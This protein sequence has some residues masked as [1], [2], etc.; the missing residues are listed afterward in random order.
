MNHLSREKSA[1]LQQH[2][3]NPVH[4]RAWSK[5]AFEVAARQKKP[6][7][8]SI[9]YSTC[10]WCHV[11]EH[12]SFESPE[13]AKILNDSFVA[14][15][16]DREEHPDIDQ[17]YMDALH[18]MVARGGWPLNVF[19]TPDRVPFFGGTYFPKAQFL[20]L[21]TNIEKVWR[22]ASG[23]IEEQGQKV[24]E[25]MKQGR[26]M[27]A[28]GVRPSSNETG[29]SALRSRW[30]SSI[31]ELANLQLRNF[32]SVWGGFGGAPKFPRSHA[33]SALLRAARVLEDPMRRQTLSHAV[34]HSLKAMAHGGIWDHL[35]GGFHRYSTDAEWH[36]PHFEKCSTTKL[37]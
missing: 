33:T 34:A 15:K 27:P 8:V 22:E 7:L 2:A 5:D 31:T 18:T 13:V 37:S 25:H 16:V 12:E 14:I 10:H 4:W 9:G 3:Q 29:I 32:D 23:Q 1:Y 17:F 19:V 28:S 6:V 26:V 30:G 36:V 35:G 21:L 24:L 11:M 20:Q